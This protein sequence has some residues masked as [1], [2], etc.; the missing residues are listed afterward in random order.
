VTTFDVIVNVLGYMPLGALFVLA[1]HPR[2]RGVVAALLA[3]VAGALLSGAIETLQT[4]L[5]TRVPSNI[6]LATNSLGALAGGL[7]AAPLASSLIDR[8]RLADIR[9]R[10]FERSASALLLI[11]SL[12]PLVQMSPEPMLFGSGDLREPLG[13][14][15]AAL[16][17]TWP[18]LDPAS[19]GPAEYVLTEAFVVAAALL[20]VGLALA[21]AMRPAAPRAALLLALVLAALAAKAL[22]HGLLFGP[23]RA[24]TWFTPGAFGGLALGLLT[25]LAA[26]AGP[27]HWRPRFAFV[28][29]AA[30]L[31][32]V[33]LVPLNPYYL[34]TMHDWRQ[35]A[36]LNF[37]ALANWLATLWPYALALALL[38]RAGA[39]RARR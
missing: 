4:Y 14:L 15:V 11:V 13:G 18:T 39:A 35:G 36:L 34:V 19:F 2:T 10:W 17:G 23:D 38:S 1:L 32:A 6:D 33:N 22:A 16:G 7:L 30:A 37:N 31:A 27:T 3:L 5:P 28:A 21:S 9:L 8:G 29:L 20:A 12:W 25:L 26:S 24:F